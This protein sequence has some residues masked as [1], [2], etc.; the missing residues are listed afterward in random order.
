MA[1]TED[2]EP[3]ENEKVRYTRIETVRMRIWLSLRMRSLVK[4]NRQDTQG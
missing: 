3:S 1:L 4:T 2:E